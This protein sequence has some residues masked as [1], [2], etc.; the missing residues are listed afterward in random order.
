MELIDRYIYEVGRHL[1]RKNRGDIQAELLSLLMDS[2]DAGE[3]EN[4]NE[5][6]SRDPAEGVRLSQRSGGF[7]PT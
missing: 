3:D 2:L 4:V 5:G 6:E 1:P 7:L